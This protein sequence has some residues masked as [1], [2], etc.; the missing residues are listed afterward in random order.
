MPTILTVLIFI[1]EDTCILYDRN[2]STNS[3]NVLPYN[4]IVNTF[5]VNLLPS[6]NR[7]TLLS[8]SRVAIIHVISSGYIQYFLLFEFRNLC[9]SLNCPCNGSNW[10]SIKYL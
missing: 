3:N 2:Q 4:I 5:F 10:H 6:S 8:V 9:G 1:L 7:E